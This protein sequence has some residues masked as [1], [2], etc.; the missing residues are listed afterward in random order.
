MH[1]FSRRPATPLETAAPVKLKPRRGFHGFVARPP[2]SLRPARV[3]IPPHPSYIPECP[4]G[5]SPGR[6]ESEWSRRDRHG[7]PSARDCQSCVGV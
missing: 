5:R 4:G 6:R 7:E 3:G 1:R 2:K